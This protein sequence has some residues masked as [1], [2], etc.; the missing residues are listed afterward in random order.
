MNKAKILVLYVKS[1]SMTDDSG[2]VNTGTS[3]HYLFWGE[4][5]ELMESVSGNADKGIGQQRAKATLPWEAST[6]FPVVPGIYE[7]EFTM[8]TGSDGKPVLKLVS[9]EFVNPVLI[10]EKLK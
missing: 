5:G 6:K 10:Q 3:C 7:G 2:H 8:A 1:Y 4:H 9:A